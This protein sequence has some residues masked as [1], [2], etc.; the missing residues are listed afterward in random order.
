M[1]LEASWE[2]GSGIHDH[3]PLEVGERY[4]DPQQGQPALQ[5]GDYLATLRL[6]RWLVLAIAAVFTIGGVLYSLT[7]KPS[8]V[9]TSEVLLS[10]Q[11]DPTSSLSQEISPDTEAQVATSPE[12]AILAKG[13]FETDMTPTEMIK[14]LTVSLPSDSFV[15]DFKF[16]APSPTTSQEG[17]NAF[18]EAYLQFKRTQIQEGIDGQI[19]SLTDRLDQLNSDAQAANKILQ[20]SPENS[21]DWLTAQTTLQ[22][23][24]TQIGVVT[25]H[26]R[27]VGLD[28]AGRDRAGGGVPRVDHR[29]GDG[30]RDRRDVRLAAIGRG[31]RA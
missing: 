20:S 2:K 27:E 17:A 29:F 13:M 10:A 26:H 5:I 9:A 19:Q 14:N 21:P 3:S 1:R 25:S 22:T 28:L 18:A 23:I 16:S 7:L 11:T 4:V 12:V 15:L 31:H 30:L 8:Y 6:R 24:Q